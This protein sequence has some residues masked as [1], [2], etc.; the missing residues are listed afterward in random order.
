L[1]V[2]PTD[3]YVAQLPATMDLTAVAR[4]DL[5]RPVADGTQVVFGISPPDSDTTTYTATTANGRAHFTGLR[6]NPGDA[7]GSWLVTALV[8]L[9]SGIELRDNASFSLLAGAPKSPGQH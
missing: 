6:V 1:T 4:D 8:T 2:T 5:G 3:V 9:P 7:V